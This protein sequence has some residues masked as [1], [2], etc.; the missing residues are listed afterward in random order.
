MI[1]WLNLLG[2]ECAFLEWVRPGV[3]GGFSATRKEA[4]E[5]KR[6]YRH[7]RTTYHRAQH[8]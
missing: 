7:R 1:C 8:M 4:E 6:R 3:V 2:T 5:E